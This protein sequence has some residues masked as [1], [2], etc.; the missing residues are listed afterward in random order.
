MDRD[1]LVTY[2]LDLKRSIVEQLN[3]VVLDKV[4]GSAEGAQDQKDHGQGQGS[5]R[6]WREAGQALIAAVQD[7][8]DRVLGVV[9]LIVALTERREGGYWQTG[10]E[11]YCYG[12]TGR[13]RDS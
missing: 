12:L 10:I 11:E 9:D 7:V 1:L 8:T 6:E 4:V 5:P 2:I 13:E 3:V